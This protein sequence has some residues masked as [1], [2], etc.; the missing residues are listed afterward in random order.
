M[1]IRLRVALVFALALAAAFALGGW[2]FV[3]QLSAAMLKST[4][5]ALAARLTQASRYTADDEEGN[6][7][8]SFL[9][10]KPGPGEYI[11]QVI[12][13]SGRVIRLSQNAGKTP[14]LSPAGLRRAR[15][16]Q[17]L[18]TRDAGGKPERVLA[19]PYGGEHGWVAIAAVSLQPSGNTLRQVTDGLLLGG[20]V[21]VIAGGIGAYWL[22]RAALAPVERL[23]REVDALSERDTQATVRVP[24]TRDEVAALAGTMNGLLV[25]LHRALARQRAFAAD[26]SHELRTP[27]AVLRGELE[28]AGRPGRSNEELSA[29]VAAAAEEAGRLT[30]LT[31]DLL[32]L[33]KGD[34]DKLSLR[35]EPT[36]I[37][38]LLTASAQRAR[39]RAAAADVTCQVSAAPGLIAVV[40][41]G[42]IRQAVDN[43][44]DNALRF[45]PPGSQVLISAETAGPALVI[46]VRDAGPGFPPEFLPHAFERFRRPGQDRARNAGGAGLGLAIVHAITLA[47]AGTAIATNQPQGGAQIRLELPHHPESPSEATQ[48]GT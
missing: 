30:R 29:A 11:V 32:L 35:L 5:A 9:T 43:L 22:A 25:R 41:A 8:A 14:L 44:I 36:D 3:S 38:S 31:D 1:P 21:F 23:R 19:G 39:S 26:A 7:P 47:H 10:S 27:F 46:E 20:A 28:L 18:L 33:A 4:D 6:L 13:P 17:V 2:L 34:E 16:G 15:H 45:A 48:P 37:T 12:G 40:D 24:G 42:R